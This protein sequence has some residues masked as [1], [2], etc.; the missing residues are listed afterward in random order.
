MA[1]GVEHVPNGGNRFPAGKRS[2]FRRGRLSARPLSLNR[3]MF[4]ALTPPEAA[5]AGPAP[6]S[7]ASRPRVFWARPVWRPDGVTAR[8]HSQKKTAP[9][10]AH[11]PAPAPPRGAGRK[12][13]ILPAEFIPRGGT[14]R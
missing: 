2:V 7:Y 1:R 5:Q 4:P 11:G 14:R 12:A 6:P 10:Q 8:A 9:V 13:L 3:S